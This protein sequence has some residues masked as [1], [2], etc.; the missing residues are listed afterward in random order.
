LGNPGDAKSVKSGVHELRFHFGPGY[1]IYY[2]YQ[3]K[4]TAIL[5]CGGTKDTQN[6]DIK[7]AVELAKDHQLETRR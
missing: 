4:T 5:L 1:R 6:R 2:V 3:S 7:K